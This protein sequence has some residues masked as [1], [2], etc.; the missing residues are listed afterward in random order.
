VKPGPIEMLLILEGYKP[1]TLKAKV[2]SGQNLPL[3]AVLQENQG[4]VFGKTWLNGI[5]MKFE[6]IGSD[7]MASAW[8]T[9]V[10]DY[11]L[12]VQETKAKTPR[13]PDFAQGPNHPIIYVS[14]NEAIDFCKWLTEREREGE[15]ISATHTY[16]LPTD[17]EWSRMAGLDSEIGDGPSQRDAN[18]PPIHPWGTAWP[19]PDGFANYADASAASLA[20][21]ES[22]RVIPSYEDGFP[23]TAPVGSFEPN[24]Y[25]L[26]DIGGNVQ[27]WVAEDI[28]SSTDS[29]LG[30][31][32]GGGWNSYIEENLLIG[33]RNP[34]PSA[35]HG[36]YYG[37]RI[38]LSKA[39]S[40]A[41]VE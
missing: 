27:E 3:N 34:V 1:F 11:E 39:E 10:K 38:V 16:R 13:K 40:N 2:N 19:P 15:R 18:K 26:F 9:R 22:D 29:P 14:R 4:V 30:V 20:G 41:E 28:S 25:G 36:S 33:W 17:V 7:L 8:E 37:F 35:F 32:R 12:F 5:G 21:T 6:P 24:E 23:R 31:V